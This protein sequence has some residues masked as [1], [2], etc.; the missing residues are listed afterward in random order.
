[1]R[2]VYP[3]PTIW[4]RLPRGTAPRQAPEMKAD[5][6]YDFMPGT[7]PVLV[8]IPHDGRT[9]PEGIAARMTDEALRI[10]DTDWHVGRLYDFAGELGA[11]VLAARHSRYVV[12]LNRDPSG[13]ALYP[14]AD[15]TE[16]VPLRTFDRE[17]V[18][19]DGAAPGEAE[20][21]ERV[22]GFWQPYH[23]RL[24]AEIG[25]LRERH[26]VAI[27]FDAHS[28]R[29]VVP[30]FFEGTLPD[31]NFGTARGTSADAALAASAFRAL[32]SAEGYSAVDNGR[33]TGGYITRS[34]GAPADRVHAIQLELSQRTYMDEAY[35][36]GYRPDL[37]DAVKPVLREMLAAMVGWARARR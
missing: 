35:P 12:D 13:A 3:G 19:R 34:Y 8:S 5:D 32:D 26:G 24:A 2:R 37:A 29:S 20:I 33:F 25:A 6:I 27:L 31:F 22:A 36:F 14:G 11:G 18:Y 7:T 17:P 30:R 15:N 28:I 1:M 21:E 16:I 10:P 23:D 4:S 9:I